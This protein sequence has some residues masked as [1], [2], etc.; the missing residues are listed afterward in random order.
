M[1]IKNL[2]EKLKYHFVDSTAV[3]TITNP[4]M[5]ALETSPLVGMTNDVS[6]NARMLG[7]TL[8]YLGLGSLYAKG[9]DLSKRIFHIT[10]ETTEKTKQ[11]HDA[12]YAVGYLL[13]LNP[14]FYYASGSRDIKE[15]A[16][17]TIAS[18][19]AGLILGGPA[20]YLIDSFRDLTGLKES[21]RVPELVKRQNSK[22]KKGIATALVVVSIGVTGL[23]YSFNRDNS[24]KYN[25]QTV[26]QTSSVSSQTLEG[27]IEKK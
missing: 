20:G 4:V 19:S 15:I 1:T 22:I 17:G 9:R 25:N 14:P 7:T 5:A 3:M 23:I 12:L 13:A 11:V 21:E 27:R 24:N 10:P 6:M 16:M 18:A 8:T 26:Q 2:T